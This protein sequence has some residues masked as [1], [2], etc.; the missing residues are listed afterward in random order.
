MNQTKKNIL[1][2]YFN[3]ELEKIIV[4]KSKIISEIRKSFESLCD[5]KR[6]PD[7]ERVTQFSKSEAD[8]LLVKIESAIHAAM[9]TIPFGIKAL[10]Q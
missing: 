7:F 1:F 6:H 10:K 9:A 5:D 2:Y 8:A 3:K 4:W